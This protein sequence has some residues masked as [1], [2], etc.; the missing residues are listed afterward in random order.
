MASVLVL[1]SS[2]QGCLSKEAMTVCSIKTTGIVE[3]FRVSNLLFALLFKNPGSA[4]Q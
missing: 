1:S 3:L 4:Y 2:A